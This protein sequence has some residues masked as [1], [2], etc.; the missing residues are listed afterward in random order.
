MGWALVS[1]K[2]RQVDSQFVR[3]KSSERLNFAVFSGPLVESKRSNEKQKNWNTEA[4]E[5][6]ERFIMKM[7]HLN[8]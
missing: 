5:S 3:V 1:L 2:S 6:T 7:S 8:R 4:V